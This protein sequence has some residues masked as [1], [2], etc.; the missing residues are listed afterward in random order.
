MQNGED[1]LNLFSSAIHILSMR[2]RVLCTAVYLYIKTILLGI[3]L[4]FN[5]KVLALDVSTFYT[6]SNCDYV[7]GLITEVS[8]QY[9]Y[10]LDVKGKIQKVSRYSIVAVEC[11]PCR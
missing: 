4:L 9:I 10:V 6:S 8:E 1:I 7:S 11:L 3:L 5:C 2:I